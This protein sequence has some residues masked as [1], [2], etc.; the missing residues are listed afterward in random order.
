MATFLYTNLCRGE[1]FNMFVLL[2]K[3]DPRKENKSVY[4]GTIKLFA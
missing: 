2:Y 3:Y 1:T 4:E